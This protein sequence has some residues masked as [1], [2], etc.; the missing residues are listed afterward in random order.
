ME[1]GNPGAFGDR[2]FPQLAPR[3][4]PDEKERHAGRILYLQL[5][6][7]PNRYYSRHSSFGQR[8]GAF[9]K[10]ANLISVTPAVVNKEREIVSTIGGAKVL[11]A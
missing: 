4:G 8:M 2:A 11:R 3:G 7:N 10:R 5:R 6:L 9:F 1:I